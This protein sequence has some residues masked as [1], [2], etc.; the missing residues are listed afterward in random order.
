MRREATGTIKWNFSRDIF[1]IRMVL[2]KETVGLLL[3]EPISTR[4]TGKGGRYQDSHTFGK[5]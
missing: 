2:R 3:K 1:D 4:K 5:E